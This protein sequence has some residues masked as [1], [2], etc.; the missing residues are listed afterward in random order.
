M[1]MLVAVEAPRPVSLLNAVAIGYNHRL[2]G[3]FGNKHAVASSAFADIPAA[4]PA[5]EGT[6]GIDASWAESAV[7][8]D[9]LVQ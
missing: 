5:A 9:S 7:K 6:A 2:A 8:L 1:A 3:A 4:G